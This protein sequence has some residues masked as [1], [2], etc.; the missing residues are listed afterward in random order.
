L[1]FSIKKLKL[2][3]LINYK[4]SAEDVIKPK[5]HSEI[6]L[7]IFL[8]FLLNPNQCLIIEDS[9]HG[10]NAAIN[11]GGFLLSIDRISDI[12]Y[13]NIT[14]KLKTI[15]NTNTKMKILKS[16]H[17]DN[18]N[19]L[20]PM[21]GVGSRFKEKGYTF[22]KPLIE[23][24]Q[25]PMI[26]VVLENINIEANYIFLVLKEH[27]EKYNLKAF[28]K[29][30][31]P[32]CKIVIVDKITEGA[33]CTALLAKKYIDNNS[34]LLIANS[35][36]YIDW[37]VSETMYSLMKP[38]IDGGILCFNSN[39]PKWSYALEKNNQIIEVAEKNPISNFATVGIYYWRKG[40]DFVK[41]ANQ[42]IKKNIRTNNEFYICPVYN[43]AIKNNKRIEKRMIDKMYGLGTPEDLEYF[44]KKIDSV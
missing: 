26:Q 38:N 39:H 29:S 44:L 15:N 42:M 43:E 5:P 24:H 34:M 10:K 11:S 40:G 4:I 33:A 9:I 28:L 17:S 8:N 27:Y 35:D 20:I 30:I 12:S 32:N 21:A 37:N 18:L 16:W 41:Y 22:P 14:N 7:N 23:V 2:T 6:Y 19:V 25:K 31:K 1:N 3:K 36:Q 13:K